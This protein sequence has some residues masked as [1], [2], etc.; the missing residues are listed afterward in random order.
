[1]RQIPRA[2]K[3]M[4]MLL[5]GLGILPGTSSACGVSTRHREAAAS[6][7]M[8]HPQG[9]EANQDA[10]SIPRSSHQE[11][12]CGSV[13][14]CL[15]AAQIDDPAHQPGEGVTTSKLPVPDSLTPSSYS[16]APG[17]PPPRV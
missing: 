8:T 3:A 2:V 14:P 1:M 12:V 17:N 11:Q 5:S 15:F 4:M 6:M 10:H 16:T 7:V 9:M 13:L